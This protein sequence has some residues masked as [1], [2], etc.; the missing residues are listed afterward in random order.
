MMCHRSIAFLLVVAAFAIRVGAVPPAQTLEDF[1]S[2]TSGFFGGSE[3]YSNPL[4]G[5]VGGVDDGFL[6]VANSIPFNLGTADFGHLFSGPDVDYEASGITGMSFWLNDVD[7]ADDFEIHVS[8]GT[9]LFDGVANMWSTTLGFVPTHNEWRQFSVDFTDAGQWTQI[10][11]TGEESFEEALRN[12]TKLMFRHD[13]AP[14]VSNPDGT[15]GEL[16]IDRIRL[17]PEPATATCLLL[18]VALV[19]KRRTRGRSKRA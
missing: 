7:Q 10:H 15:S 12:V 3:S 4:T 16:G 6:R 13:R 9:G 17:T 14:I 1:S 5:G 19:L 18:G 8:I 2:G 11:G